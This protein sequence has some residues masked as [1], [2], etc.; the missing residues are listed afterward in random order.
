MLS[1]VEA[2]PAGL[3]ESSARDLH[4]ILDGPTVLHLTGERE[5]PIFLCVLQHG[6]ED[7][8]WEAL[9]RL[10]FAHRHEP[11][12]RSLIVLIANVEAARH[13]LRQLDHQPDFNRCWPG[14]A[15]SDHPLQATLAAFLD[16]LKAARP[17]LG[18]D[19]HNNS[20]RN[21]HYAA[22]N[23]L[24]P[25]WLYLASLFDQRAVYYRHPKGTL[26]DALSTFMPGITIEC[27]EI[28]GRTAI[29]HCL[30]YLEQLL[31]IEQLPARLPADRQLQLHQ[32]IARTRVAPEVDFGFG[33]SEGCD[34]DFVAG[35]DRYNFAPL[36]PGTVL[37]R[38]RSDRP[39]AIQALTQDDIDVTDRYLEVGD[40]VLR[41]RRPFVP[42]MLSTDHR[43]VRQDCLCYIM[44]PME[45]G[46]GA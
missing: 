1:H 12:P 5:P 13:G 43:I 31:Q 6:N 27:G 28:G 36:A 26:S 18:V 34:I 44:E 30:A 20:G 38:V 19:I 37:A 41:V 2:I 4:R 14:A 9:R 40:G 42:A 45:L 11:L 23:R 15:P 16:Q 3:L 35:I 29:S 39:G 10:L 32:T 24:A 46:A 8:G 21:P 7:S 33:P 17:L 22:I 25:Q